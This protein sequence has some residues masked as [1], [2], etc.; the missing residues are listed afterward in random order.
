MYGLI[1]RKVAVAG[2]RETLIGTLVEGLTDMRGCF[3][4]V[5]AKDPED[6]DGIWITQVWDCEKSYL[7]S[8]ALAPMQKALLRCTS[9]I[10]SDGQPITTQPVVVMD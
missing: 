9:L 3:S 8:L 5:L 7:E 10:A 2:Q 4:Y 6:P 1:V